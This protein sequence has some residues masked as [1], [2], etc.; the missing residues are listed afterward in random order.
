MINSYGSCWNDAC[1]MRRWWKMNSK[2]DM[3]IHGSQMLRYINSEA[4]RSGKSA[5]LK[6]MTNCNIR[7]PYT[8]IALIQSY[9][10][11]WCWRIVHACARLVAMIVMSNC[12][13]VH[14]SLH[15][16]DCSCNFNQLKLPSTLPKLLAISHVR[17]FA[18]TT[19]ANVVVCSMLKMMLVTA[20]KRS[21]TIDWWKSACICI[22]V[23]CRVNSLIF[24]NLTPDPSPSIVERGV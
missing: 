4:S 20:A 2:P 22:I 3:I 10:K 17:W 11:R 9:V 12:L 14:A 18:E 16:P 8:L 1:V 19:R 13:N 6:T 15:Q 21:I 23:V 7:Q 24:F 5:K